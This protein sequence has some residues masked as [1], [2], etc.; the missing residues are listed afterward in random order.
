MNEIY[1]SLLELQSI[2]REIESAE[3]NLKKF[4]PQLDELEAPLRTLQQETDTARVRL[5][6][7]R[8]Q[9]SKLDQAASSKRDR[10]KTYDARLDKVR[11][12]REEAAVRTEMD[13]VRSAIDA[14]EQEGLELME[15]SRRTDLK[16]DEME[17]QLAKLRSETEPKKEELLA[18]R[19]ALEQELTN[20]RDRRNNQAMR[21]DPPA[22]RLYDRVRMGKKRAALAPMKADGACGSCFNIIPVQEQ[23]EIRRGGELKRCEGCGVI[24]YPEEAAG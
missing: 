7:M 4:D 1:R 9:S 15:Q 20:L 19:V 13:L 12:P 8:Q 24:L 10:L 16:L 11:N 5:A 22:A 2:D 17:K 14:D 6:E 18:A 21:I 23:T 3:A